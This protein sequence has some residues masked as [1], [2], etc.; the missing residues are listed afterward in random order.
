MI[1][2]KPV[3]CA[4]MHVNIRPVQIIFKN[5]NTDKLLDF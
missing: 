3:R 4:Q 2:L 1:K 5:S